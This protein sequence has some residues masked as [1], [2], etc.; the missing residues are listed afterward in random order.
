MTGFIRKQEHLI[1]LRCRYCCQFARHE[2]RVTFR[3]T[4]SVDR[5]E[6]HGGAIGTSWRTDQNRTT[7][8]TDQNIMVE[9]SEHHG[10]PIGTSWLM[11]DR[12]EHHGKPIR[13]SWRSDQNIMAN[14]SEHHGGAIRTSS[15][16][17]QNNMADGGAIR[18]S[19]R[20]DQVQVLTVGCAGERSA[21]VFA[22]D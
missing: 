21:A 20:S 2:S 14:R 17:D 11:A 3:G 8:R 19:W 7:W 10:K 4:R 5:S 22:G 1:F 12:S 6:Q 13:T 18:T 15:R 9:R 16:S